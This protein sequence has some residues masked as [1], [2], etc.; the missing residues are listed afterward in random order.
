MLLTDG[1]VFYFYDRN[2]SPSMKEY[3]KA[4]I[5]I[6]GGEDMSKFQQD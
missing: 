6:N 5:T 4:L 2:E 1:S 3:L